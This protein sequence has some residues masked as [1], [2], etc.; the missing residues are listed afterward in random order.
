LNVALNGDG[1]TLAVA[2]GVN[3]A[4][5]NGG[6]D[7]YVFEATAA[8]NGVDQI[9]DFSPASDKLDLTAW[10]GA[11]IGSAS[12]AIDAAAGGTF[13][14]NAARLERVY[15]KTDGLLSSTDFSTTAVAGKLAQQLGDVTLVR[16]MVTDQFNHAPAELLLFTGAGR[17]GR[18]SMGAWFAYGLGSDNRDL[19]AFVVLQSGGTLPSAGKARVQSWR[20]SMSSARI[21]RRCWS[22]A[23]SSDY[24][25]R[26]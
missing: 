2:A 22:M 25:R 12:T 26:R 17:P 19:P 18:P 11:T 20:G 14:G 10:I 16:S 3:V 1:G 13:F 7:R 9:G 6:V 4:G 21:S 8:L 15:N 5:S 23:V 24:G